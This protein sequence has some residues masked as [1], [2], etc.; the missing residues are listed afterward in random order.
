[1][2][3]VKA[4]V[5]K[6]QKELEE[7]KTLQD[8]A[9]LEQDKIR[10]QQSKIDTEQKQIAL[11][12]KELEAKANEKS[13]QE[14]MN[15]KKALEIEE[16]KLKLEE[17]KL[18]NERDIAMKKLELKFS[19]PII[20]EKQ[21]NQS[22]D[23]E[24][25]TLNDGMVE[26]KEVYKARRS[27]VIAGLIAPLVLIG[28]GGVT[29]AMMDDHAGSKEQPVKTYKQAVEKND[30]KTVAKKYPEKLDEY[31]KDLL[32][33]NDGKS[34]NQLEKVTDNK[35]VNFRSELIKRNPVSIKKAFESLN[36]YDGLSK[37]ELKNVADIYMADNEITEVKKINKVLNDESISKAL[38]KRAFY[39]DKK[40][41]LEKIISDNNDANAVKVAKSE[42]QEVK[43]I[44][45][46]S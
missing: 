40:K 21:I 12:E 24:I 42:L 36:D 27:G 8:Q 22:P 10:L 44:L 31:S 23:E 6:H 19:R 1:M 39:E 43:F 14:E 9:Q 4:K 20:E 26:K 11:E 17:D 18:Q 41:T 16:R 15:K 45:N 13:L 5:Q 46:E 29:Y 35:L 33:E 3:Q 2:L 7:Q 28:A 30:Y 25:G 32:E 38:K 34:L 37:D